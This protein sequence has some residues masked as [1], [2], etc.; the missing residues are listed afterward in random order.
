VNGVATRNGRVAVLATINAG[1][2]SFT[3]PSALQPSN[4][5]VGSSNVYL[6]IVDVQANYPNLS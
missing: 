2:T 6:A 5:V 4:D 3:T 1:G